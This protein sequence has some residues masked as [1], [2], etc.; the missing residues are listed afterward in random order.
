MQRRIEQCGSSPAAR[1]SPRKMPAKSRAGTAA[2]WRA[3]SRALRVVGQDHLA[4]RRRCD[5]VEEHVLGAAQADA[6]AR[7]T[8]RARRASSGVSALA[9]TPSVRMSSAQASSGVELARPRSGGDRR[10]LAEDDS[11]GRAVDAS[12]Q[13]PAL[14]DRVADP[15]RVRLA[16]DFER[17]AA[18][19]R[20]L[21][22]RAR[23]PPRATS[24]RRARSDTRARA[25]PGSRRR[26]S[27][28]GPASPPRP[29][30]PRPRPLGGRRRPC[31]S[32]RRDWPATGR[33]HREL[34]AGS[35]VRVQQLLDLP[36]LDPRGPPRSVDQPSLG[37]IDGD[38]HGGL[39]G[40]LA[41]AGLQHPE[42]ASLDRELE[43]LHV[44]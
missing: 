36:A 29:A 37:H 8:S 28:A 10:R 40:P 19:H 1:P 21:P 11:P 12:G 42:L 38:P 9:R 22:I 33:D 44:A 6:L 3:P 17:A 2:A 18:G 4:H 39:R 25:M 16:V 5:R 30:S 35:I 13:S 23:R 26:A 24:S 20:G 34:C 27:P 43:V 14:D 7:R 32:P 41:G 15:D 31:R